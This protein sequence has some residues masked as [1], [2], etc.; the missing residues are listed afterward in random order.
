[1]DIIKNLLAF[2]NIVR[3]GLAKR[4][5]IA[6]ISRLS[7]ANIDSEAI[8]LVDDLRN[9]RLDKSVYIGAFTSLIVVNQNEHCLNSSLEIGH[10]TY[11]G[12]YNNIRASGGRIKIGRNCL[13]SQHISLVATNHEY[14]KS[15]TIESQS[16]RQTNNFIDIGDDVWIGAHSV[17]LPGVTIGDGAIIGAG[18]VVTKSVAS[19]EIVAGNPAKR[20]KLRE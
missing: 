5:A 16:W 19:Y 7:G 1:M 14:K 18:S 15:A 13:I 17:I 12:E 6:K 11:V 10:N 20:I 2:L 8:I 3:K 9:L 4:Y